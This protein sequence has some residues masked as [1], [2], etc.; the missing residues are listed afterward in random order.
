MVAVEEAHFATVENPLSLL[1]RGV[2]KQEGDP[3]GDMPCF[4]TSA[5]GPNF[6][7][8]DVIGV[9]LPETSPTGCAG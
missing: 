6:G 1:Q 7:P 8:P 3:C 4:A 2:D 5:V 9:K